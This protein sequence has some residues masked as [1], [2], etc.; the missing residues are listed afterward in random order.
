MDKTVNKDK[1]MRQLQLD[2]LLLAGIL[3]YFTPETIPYFPNAQ[4]DLGRI[5]DQYKYLK[6][7]PSSDQTFYDEVEKCSEDLKHSKEAVVKTKFLLKR[8]YNASF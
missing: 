4:N 2:A 3:E 6:D 1:R 5:V 8:Y 7:D